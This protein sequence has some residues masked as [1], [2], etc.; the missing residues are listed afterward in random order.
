MFKSLKVDLKMSTAY[1][2]QSDGQTEH[3]NHCLEAY[4]RSM[5]FTEQKKWCS[6]LSLV[7]WW[8]N[9]SYHTATQFT[10]FH[11]LY[12]FPAP[13]ISEISVAGP[14]DV[15]AQAFLAQ[16]ETMLQQLKA[17]LFQ[18]QHRMKK[19]ADTNRTACH[20][21]VGDMVYIK[22]QPYRM[23]AF[24]VKHGLKLATKYY[25]P[26]RVQA[27]VGQVAYRLLLPQGTQI[28]NVFHVSQLKKHLGPKAIP[29]PHLPLIDATGK[30]HTTPV[31]VLETR[32]VPCPPVLVSQWLVQWLNM[33]P[34]EATWED[35]D[36]MKTAFPD[37]FNATIRR[38]FPS[39]HPRG[40]GCASQGGNCQDPNNAATS[41]TDDQ[42]AQALHVMWWPTGED[43]DG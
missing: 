3:V 31:M 37:F 19:Y 42:D 18:A 1:H 5:A 6:W 4:L 36:F 11:A 24:D 30:I 38:W 20:F 7:E 17:N 14:Q 9:S 32:A 39:N 10:P 22:L 23:A 41:S 16:K 27:K 15:D 2:P 29:V 21:K 12:G 8:Y 25:G 13:M 40:Q 33:S 34:E 43:R 28:H 35:A 26:Y